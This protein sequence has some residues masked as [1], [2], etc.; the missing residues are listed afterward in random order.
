MDLTELPKCTV[1]LE[2]MDESVNGVLTTLCNHSFHSQCLQRWEDA[3]WVTHTLT[4]FSAIPDRPQTKQIPNHSFAPISTTW[5]G[6]FSAHC[7][8]IVPFQSS[9]FFFCFFLTEVMCFSI[10][11]LLSLCIRHSYKHTDVQHTVYCSNICYLFLTKK[12]KG[13]LGNLSILP[14]SFQTVSWRVV[15]TLL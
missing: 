13:L 5:C 1:C 8:G 3:S 9:C 7:G 2:R 6:L 11:S 4:H 12:K 10:C 15:F 14:C